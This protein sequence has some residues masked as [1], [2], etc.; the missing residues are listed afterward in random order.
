MV[1]Y[2]VLLIIGFIALIKGA[3]WFVKGSSDIAKNLRIPSV[4]I[5][6]TIVA[7]GTSAPELAVSVAAAIQ[8]ANEISVSN[9][10]GSNIFNLMVVLGICASIHPLEVDKK[11]LKRDMPISILA[12][13]VTLGFCVEYPLLQKIKLS[14]LR[15]TDEAGMIH[16]WLGVALIISFAIYLYLLICDA[17]KNPIEEDDVQYLPIWKCLVL[18]IVG[19]V[20]IIGGGQAVVNGAREIARMAGMTE[21]LIGLTIVA[22]GTSLPELVTSIVASKKGE[23]DLAI[24]NAVGSNIFN[25]LLILGLSGTIH[26]MTINL[27]TIIDIIILILC[28]ILT[29]I[30]SRTAK[31]INRLEGLSM[32]ILYVIYVGY[33]I[34]R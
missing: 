31:R 15:A 34:L 20:L 23:T 17:R 22:V 14:R 1:T 27:A 3:D 10:V 30:Y 2:I 29:F 21:T 4:I 24:G 12:T 33:A 13:I 16:R 28:S 8:G 11:I 32:V 25:L 18:V 9:V 26:P 6:L 19:L 7:L 5:G